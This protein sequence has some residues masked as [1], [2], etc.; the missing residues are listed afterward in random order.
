MLAVTSDELIA[1]EASEKVSCY[2]K[3]IVLCYKKE[4]EK[5]LRNRKNHLIVNLNQWIN[6]LMKLY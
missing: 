6:I 4:K 5:I 2:K 1:Q 3:Y